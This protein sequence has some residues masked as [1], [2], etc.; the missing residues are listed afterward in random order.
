M[1][2]LQQLMTMTYLSAVSG[3]AAYLHQTV[4]AH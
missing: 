3:V 4:A 2:M 1:M